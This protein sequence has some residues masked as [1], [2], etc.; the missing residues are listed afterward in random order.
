MIQQEL[1]SPFADRILANLLYQ[2]ATNHCGPYSAT[3]VINTLKNLHLNPETI[4]QELNKPIVRFFVPIARRIP[5]SATF[6]WGMVDIFNQ[7]GIKASWHCF[8]SFNH[9]LDDFQKGLILLP[10]IASLKPFWAHIMI[11]IIVHPEKGVGFANTQI[12]YPVIDWITEK[13][14]RQQWQLTFNCVVEVN[15]H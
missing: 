1:V 2:G 11:L 13:Q 9:L 7:F 15:P 3:T 8:T 10:V 12:A 4:A 6:P 5:N 14:F